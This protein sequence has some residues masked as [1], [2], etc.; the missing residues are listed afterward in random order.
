MARPVYCGWA[1]GWVCGLAAISTDHRAAGSRQN[2]GAVIEDAF[3]PRELTE[4]VLG[5]RSS[6]G[7][8]VQKRFE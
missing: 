7:V 6:H 1:S 8:P 5:L 2:P 3:E 4:H